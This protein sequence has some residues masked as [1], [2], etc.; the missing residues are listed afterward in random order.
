MTQRTY[1]IRDDVALPE[2]IKLSKR[3]VKDPEI[4]EYEQ[5]PLTRMYVG[6]SVVLK[7]YTRARQLRGIL[8]KKPRNRNMKFIS[9]T[10]KNGKGVRVWRIA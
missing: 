4:S 2:G 8:F 5:V 10:L 1:R 9:R 7:D 3:T 6:S